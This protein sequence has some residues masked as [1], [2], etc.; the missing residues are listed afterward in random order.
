MPIVTLSERGCRGCTLCVDICPVKVF[1]HDAARNL[2]VVARQQDCI[3]CLSC[4]YACPSQCVTVSDIEVLRPFHRIESHVALI[5]R[6]LQEK[7]ASRTL[8]ADDV[9]EASRDVAARLHAL[10]DAIVETMGRGHK[11]VGRRAGAVAAAHLPEVYEATGLDGVLAGVRRQMGQAFPFDYQQS[12][13]EV[14]VTFDPCG[15]C[16]VVR[17]AGQSVGQ[18]VLCEVFHEYWAGLL[19]AYVGAQYKVEMATVG[20]VCE[21]KLQPARQ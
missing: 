21:M 9:A 5:E 7:A 12:G 15:L 6:F 1:D 11:P 8:T 4:Y 17:D 3:G 18:A 19:S 10:A 14:A 16:Q 20:D 2:A 13:S